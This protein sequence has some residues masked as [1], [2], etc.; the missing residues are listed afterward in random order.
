[1]RRRLALAVPLLLVA[2]M[3]LASCG[4]SERPYAERRQWPLMPRRPRSE[5]PR[6]RGPVLLVRTLRTG[7]G[8]DSRGLQSLQP[9]GSIRTA[10]Y[11]EWAAPPAQAAEE[12]LRGWLAE[13]GVFAAVI[14]QGSRVE[15]DQVLEGELT[16][17]WTVPTI[18]QAHCAMGITVLDHRGANVRVR[19]QQRFAAE[20]ALAGPSPR[21]AVEAQ[22]AALAL[23]FSRIEAAL[24]I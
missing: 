17:L 16:A 10:F 21:E 15:A 9:D 19:L 18:G 6:V 3:L 2:P 12:A 7:P 4:L 13:S 1:M 5:A 14:A 8:L 23:V 11:E 20:A 22:A 24:R